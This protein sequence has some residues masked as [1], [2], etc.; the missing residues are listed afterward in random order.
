MF[1]AGC[2][3]TIAN[4]SVIEAYMNGQLT[5]SRLS[6]SCEK[7]NDCGRHT[8]ISDRRG[9]LAIN[10][11]LTS[12]ASNAD[13]DEI[14]Q[15]TLV[16]L[17]LDDQVIAAPTNSIIIG[18]KTILTS[19]SFDLYNIGNKHT[20]STAHEVRLLAYDDSSRYKSDKIISS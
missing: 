9:M 15:P 8:E 3:N 20:M 12:Q 2:V 10:N 1:L 14:S 6:S 18:K 13:P 17:F 11:R 16:G 19:R 5:A 4:K 7:N